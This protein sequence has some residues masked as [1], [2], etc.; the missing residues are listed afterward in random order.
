MLVNT[1][2]LSSLLGK[3][4]AA[5][6]TYASKGVIDRFIQRTSRLDEL[7]R[8]NRLIDDFNMDFVVCISI[9]CLIAWP[10][11]ALD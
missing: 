1:C 2:L 9:H 7:E 5:L 11:A 8:Y 3:V 6:E 10:T 4:V